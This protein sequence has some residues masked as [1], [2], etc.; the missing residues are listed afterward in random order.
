MPL[1]GKY[2][3]KLQSFG[4]KK[5]PKSNA[6]ET[7]Q[8][9]DRVENMSFFYFYYL[10]FFIFNLLILFLCLVITYGDNDLKR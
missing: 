2:F 4:K 7:M 3:L 5:T 9:L 6:S 1:V 10:L 8:S